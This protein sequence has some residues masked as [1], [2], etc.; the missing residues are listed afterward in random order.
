MLNRTWVEEISLNAK[1]AWNDLRLLF[2]QQV[3]PILMALWMFFVL[4]APIAIVIIILWYLDSIGWRSGS[5]FY[6]IGSA[7]MAYAPT[8]FG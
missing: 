6:T 7:V 1:A 8:L 5:G 4:S 2:V 3:L